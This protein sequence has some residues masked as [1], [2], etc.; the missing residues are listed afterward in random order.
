VADEAL[1]RG[2]LKERPEAQRRQKNR[3][4]MPTLE[5]KIDES[6]REAGGPATA[7]AEMGDLLRYFG[8]DAGLEKA[9]IYRGKIGKKK[10]DRKFQTRLARAKKGLRQTFVRHH[11]K[12]RK[13]ISLDV[14]R[15]THRARAR[16]GGSEKKTKAL[17]PS[18]RMLEKRVNRA[19]TNGTGICWGRKYGSNARRGLKGGEETANKPRRS[20][21]DVSRCQ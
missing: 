20:A 7:A 15:T 14:R 21:R 12:N 17:L 5:K 10:S 8:L 11:Q 9:V 2:E 13:K 6:G 16:V 3:A 4:K 18:T 1:A 19:S